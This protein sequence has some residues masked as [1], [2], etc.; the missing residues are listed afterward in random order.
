MVSSHY[1]LAVVLLS[2]PP[3]TA[4]QAKIAAMHAQLARPIQALAVQWQILDQ[5]ETKDIL[6][7]PE[8]FLSDLTLVRRR[9]HDLRNAPAVEDSQRFPDWCRQRSSRLQSSYP[10][11][12]VRHRGASPLWEFR[13]AFAGT[14]RLY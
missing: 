2:N 13:Q 11:I 9:Y 10:N 4:D 8:D 5:R 14:E 7:R 6:S 3:G 1:I 12:D